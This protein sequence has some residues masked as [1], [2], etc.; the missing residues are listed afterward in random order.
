MILDEITYFFSKRNL[1]MTVII[2]ILVV[3]YFIPFDNNLHI[4][5]FSSL[6]IYLYVNRI[7]K[8][9]KEGFFKAEKIYKTL[10]F[11]K[12]K[13]IKNDGDM[14]LCITNLENLYKIN[15]VE[16]RVLL[17]E[18]NDFYRLNHE[19]KNSKYKKQIYD[20]SFYKSKN[21]LNI[22]NSYGV[23]INVEGTNID[24]IH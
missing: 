4:L 17:N 3:I 5:I 23:N 15:K 13:Y 7:L 14:I 18:I 6:V 21:I 11:I 10:D 1:F 9:K 2:S 20:N 19:F 12:Y 24:K 22:I 8:E 16:Y